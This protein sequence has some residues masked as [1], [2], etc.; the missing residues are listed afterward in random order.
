LWQP[1]N[2]AFALRAFGFVP[3]LGKKG[4]KQKKGISKRTGKPAGA[5]KRFFDNH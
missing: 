2:A 5:K 3:L 4:R 1:S